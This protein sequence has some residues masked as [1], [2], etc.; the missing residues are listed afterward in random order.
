MERGSGA[1]VIEASVVAGYVVAWA[2]RKAR[3]IGGRLDDEVDA[4]IDASLDRLH[5]VVEAKLAGHPVLAELVEEAEADNGSGDVRDRT[6]QQ[7]ELALESAAE[8]DETFRRA[9]TELATRLQAAEQETGIRIAG[10]P[11]AAVFTGKAEAKADNGGIAIGQVGR[12]VN[13][14][15]RRPDPSPTDPMRPGSDHD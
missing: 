1:V 15:R 11:G 7:I 14:S 10:S 6:R 9:V 5:E 3:R 12:D 8:R 4:A 13:F 2:I